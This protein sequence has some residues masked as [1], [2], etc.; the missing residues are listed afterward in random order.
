MYDPGMTT[1]TKVDV[2]LCLMKPKP[3]AG[4]KR[5]FESIEDDSEDDLED[6]SEAEWSEPEEEATNEDHDYDPNKVDITYCD[7]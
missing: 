1:G 7:R 6:D 4:R 2:A 5:I 3:N